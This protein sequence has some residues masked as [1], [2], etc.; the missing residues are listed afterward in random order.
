MLAIQ[1]KVFDRSN[2]SMFFINR[3]TFK[4]YDFV[5]REDEYNRVLGLDYN[6]ASKDG[7]WNGKFYGHKSFQPDDSNGNYS[8]G[9]FLGRTTKFFNAFADVVYI[10]EDFTSDLGFIRRTDIVKLATSVEKVFWPKS[11]VINS[12]GLN[13]FPIVTWRPGLDYQKTDHDIMLTGE[14]GFKNQSQLSLGFNNSYTFLT[15]EFDPTRTDGVPLPANTGYHFNSLSLQYMSNR[16]DV[17]SVMGESTLGRFFNGNIFQ[18]MPHFFFAYF[19]KHKSRLRLTITAFRY[20]TLIRVPI[21][22]C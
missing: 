16:A 22:G 6:L 5:D 13:L 15:D 17:L 11:E 14:I 9:A 2:I 3:Q 8:V 12:Y 20:P 1:K 18:L 19:Q 7:K 21:C 10:D 4:D